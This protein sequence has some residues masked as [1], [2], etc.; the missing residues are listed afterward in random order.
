MWHLPCLTDDFGRTP[1]ILEER[2]QGILNTQHDVSAS[3]TE[4]IYKTHELQR[5]AEPLLMMNEHG[6]AV[7]RLGASP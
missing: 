5:V 4:P 7:Y 3:C 1:I 2:Q 6:P